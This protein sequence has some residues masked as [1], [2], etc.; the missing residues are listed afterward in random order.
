MTDTVDYQHADYKHNLPDWVLTKD[1]VAGERAV[2]DKAE[3]YLPRPNPTDLSGEAM[4]RYAHY[5]MRAV[6]T[7]FVGR[8]HEGLIGVAFKKSPSITVPAGLDYLME[9]TD[10]CGVGLLG[11]AQMSLSH[12]L[13][14]GR[15]GL[16]VDYPVAQAQVSKADM[17]EKGIRATI[18]LYDPTSITNWK[19][20]KIGS[21]NVLSLVVIAETHETE[22]QF[23]SQS[24]AQYRVL[25]L[26]KLESEQDG[27]PI[28]Y[29]VEIWRKDAT[30]QKWAMVENFQPVD[31]TGKAWEEI[32]FQFIG[33]KNNDYMPDKSPLYDLAVLNIAHYRNSADFE[34]SAFLVGQ[35]TPYITGLDVE[36][37]DT[38][39]REKTYFG[40]RAVMTG[41][42]GSSIGLLQASA[43]SLVGEAMKEKEKQMQALGARLIKPGEVL[44]TAREI[45]SDDASAYSVLSLACDNVSEGYEQAILWASQFMN[46]TGAI[47]FEINTEFID[48]KIDAPALTAVVAAWQAGKVP[49][50]DGYNYLRRI[51]VIDAAKPNEDVQDEIATQTTGINLDSA[52]TEAL[53]T[54]VT[55]NDARQMIAARLAD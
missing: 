50:A 42:A 8:T 48:A 26:G 49:D 34:D 4:A 40:S 36:W 55:Q 19:T 39:M 44:K 53:P 15:V 7:N 41:P 27:A 1:A 46:V 17:V 38:L 33:S 13:Q 14:F 11:H 52:D 3:H 2:K 45:Q 47:E 31:G 32:P 16:L 21:R 5:K 9:D 51:G 43:N 20:A 24:A 37:R 54:N 28:R 30:T 23:D 25:R 29:V 35:P 22:G 6:Y 12:V 10:G 18:T